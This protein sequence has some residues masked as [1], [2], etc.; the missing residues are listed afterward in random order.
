MTYCIESTKQ[1]AAYVA[2]LTLAASFAASL[3]GCV[4]SGSTAQ[5]PGAAADTPQAAACTQLATLA[6]GDGKVTSAKWVTGASNAPAYCLVEG[7]LEPRTGVPAP[8]NKSGGAATN[9]QYGMHF[10][11]RLPLKWTGRFFYQGGGGSDGIVLPA[12]GVIPSWR[13]GPS[14]LSRGFAVV[15]SDAGHS[16]DQNAGFGVD[17]RARLDYG[18]RSIG[19]VTQA[20]KR[21]IQAFYGEAPKHSYFAGCSKGGQ[22]ALQAMQRYG[23]EFDGIISGDPGYRLPHAAIAQVAD[24]QAFSRAAPKS[25]DGRVMLGRAF[26]QGDLNLIA[27]AV[28]GQCGNQDGAHDGFIYRPDSCRFDP[29]V[30]QC[31]GAKTDR[32]LL[33]KQVAALHAVFNGAKTPDG[34][35]LYTPWPYDTGIASANWREW[36][37][38]DDQHPSRA[39]T[40]GAGSM[41]YVFSTPP[42]QSFDIYTASLSDLAQGIDN[43][44]PEYPQSAT[45]FMDADSVDLNAFKARGG[46]LLIYHGGSDPVFSVT[47]TI[48]YY[49]K[50]HQ[51]YGAQ[52][53]A[54]A[55]L[56]IVPGMNH[57]S[58]G[59][60]ALDSFDSLDAMVKWVE[61]GQ[62]PDAITAHA[63]S[64]SGSKLAA[65]LTRPLCPYPQTARYTKGDPHDAS[66]FVC[67]AN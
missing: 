21:V 31:K 45:Q 33:P 55:R 56:Y 54:F 7:V 6:L 48:D 65:G 62:A 52:T 61:D 28:R 37:L 15:S 58:G 1:R 53:G 47:D 66:S 10:Q 29:V 12:I 18:Y 5:T 16:E 14:A 44:T 3:A 23:S 60:Y 39:E 67:A 43:T 9:A 36:K 30:L 4:Q 13:D 8:V 41:Q 64:K 49:Q 32:C 46:K 42:R 25:A 59:D 50:L 2:A 24:T 17:P 35:V 27:D 11:L 20:A 19:P 57:C 22:E 26:S 51:A 38:G 63:G 40:L 34:R